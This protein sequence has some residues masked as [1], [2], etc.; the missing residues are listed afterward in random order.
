MGGDEQM[1]RDN[2]RD[3]RA[4]RKFDEAARAIREVL[5][6]EGCQRRMGEGTKAMLADSRRTLKA[7]SER[8]QGAWN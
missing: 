3:T 8:V 4:Q 5:E 6:D 2:A 1:A 7:L